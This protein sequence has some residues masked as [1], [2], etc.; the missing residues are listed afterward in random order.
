MSAGRLAGGLFL[1]GMGAGVLAV[2]W[3]GWRSGVLPAG[4]S[5][6]RAFRPTRDDNPLAFHFFFALYLCGGIALAAWGLLSLA[7][8]AEPLKLR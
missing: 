4:T 7:G 3:S 6:F 2:A 1:L 5:F 8:L